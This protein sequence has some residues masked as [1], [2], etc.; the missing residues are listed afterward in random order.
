MKRKTMRVTGLLCLLCIAIGAAIV[1]RMYNKPH[2]SATT[3]KAVSLTAAQLADEYE[4]DEAAANKKYLGNA[5]QVSGKVNEVTLNQQNKS[6]ILL[7]GATMSGVQCTMEDKLQPIKKGDSI[8][9]KGFCNGYLND[10]IIDRAIVS[11]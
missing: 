6:V 8:I 10:V 1:Y 9:I 11:K 2:R 4:K 3:E 7:A 5:V